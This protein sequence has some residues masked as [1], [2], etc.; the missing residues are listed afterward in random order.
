[1]GITHESHATSSI[2]RHNT[3]I[4][5]AFILKACIKYA[6]ACFFS[7]LLATAIVCYLTNCGVRF[8]S[9]Q[10]T[11]VYITVREGQIV[12]GVIS[13]VPHEGEAAAWLEGMCQVIPLELPNSITEVE[14]GREIAANKYGKSIA[15]LQ[16]RSNSPAAPNTSQLAVSFR[17]IHLLILSLMGSLLIG[18]FIWKDVRLLSRVW[19]GCCY[20]CGY[21]Q[22]QFGSLR[23][24]E[25]G[26]VIPEEQRAKLKL[27]VPMDAATSN[28]AVG[29][30]SARIT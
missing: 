1:M 2:W 15:W 12:T 6:I 17:A 4:S 9:T 13:G 21:P 18:H 20:V 23:C 7:I 16:S 19:R 26:T 10:A 24:P 27:A 3:P 22:I 30:D 8:H 11:T 5:R 14:N 28:E 25:C 29:G